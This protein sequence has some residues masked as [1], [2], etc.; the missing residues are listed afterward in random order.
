M[1]D[2]IREA[3]EY[4]VD[5]G[6]RI[7]QEQPETP[8]VIT[9]LDD[10]YVAYKGELKRYEK[11]E[12]PKPDSTK[13][14]SLNGLIDFIHADV[15]KFFA[16]EDERCIVIVE[17]PTEVAVLTPC[18]GQQN[19]RHTLAFCKYEAPR[20]MFNNY[21]PAE[22]LGIMVQ[23]NFVEDNNRDTILKIL[24]N[25]TEEQSLQTADDGVSQR[26]TIKQGVKEID[27]TVFKN[28]A[29]LRPLRTFTEVAQPCSP[30]VVRFKENQQ[31]ALF[32]SDGGAW[33]VE[34]VQFIGAYLKDKLADCNVVVIA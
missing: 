2:N 10:T 21:M 28:P 6:Q 16:K 5:V 4:L 32:E 22:D 15:D 8:E 33:R 1:E 12:L 20:I 24:R 11:H 3:L 9:I 23:T 18:K 31:A 30:F 19:G 27:S 17:S 7:S 26:V 29:F 34:A 25:M 14:F 13:I